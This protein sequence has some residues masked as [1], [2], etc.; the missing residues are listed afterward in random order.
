MGD[1]ISGMRNFEAEA[2]RVR[3]AMLPLCEPLHDVFTTAEALRRDR[4][5][6]LDVPQYRWLGT[7]CIRGFAHYEMNRLG[8]GALG[9]WTLS[10]N[11]A[12]NGEL[13]LTDGDYCIRILHG[14]SDEQVPPP[15]T[16]LSRRAYYS[17]PR[18]AAQGKLF[19]PANDRLLVLWRIGLKSGAPAFRVVRT[20]GTWKFGSTAETDLD[21][22]LPRQASDLAALKF[23]PADEE[24]ELELPAEENGDGHAGGLSG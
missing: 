8:P 15:G 22:M 4:L 19:G 20:I 1:I 3:Q 16:N 6:M 18:L 17:N 5:P 21:F 7:H 12:R 23:V 14:L 24:L 9:D 2:D 13:W 11:H 10:G